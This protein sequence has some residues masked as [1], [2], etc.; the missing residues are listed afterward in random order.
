VVV[1]VLFQEDLN[2]EIDSAAEQEFLRSRLR[3]LREFVQF[4]EGLLAGV[5]QYRQEVDEQLQRVADNWRL[6]RMA[7]TDRS[8]LRLAAYEILYCRGTPG[9]VVINEAIELA[10]RYGTR[11]SSQFV[12]GLLDR[13][14]KSLHDGSP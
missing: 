2:P 5:R 3:D 12:N 11:Q 6:N 13:L 14:Y 4:A 10:K 7:A 1:Q 9:S 8:I